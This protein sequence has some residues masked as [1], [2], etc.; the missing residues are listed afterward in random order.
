MIRDKNMCRVKPEAVGFTLHVKT[1]ADFFS[2]KNPVI[3][4]RYHSIK[5]EESFGHLNK[6]ECLG[7]WAFRFSKCPAN[8][9]WKIAMGEVPCN[10]TMKISTGLYGKVNSLFFNPVEIVWLAAW[11][12]PVWSCIYR[13]VLG[14]SRMQQQD[15]VW[16][17]SWSTGLP[18]FTCLWVG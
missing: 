1:F 13:N 8:S 10:H 14:Q 11:C 4:T 6:T 15:V 18:S 2:K 16:Y 17:L 12:V 9:G 7:E 3:P 5:T